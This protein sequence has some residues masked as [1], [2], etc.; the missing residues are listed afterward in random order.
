MMLLNRHLKISLVTRHIPLLSVPAELD[1]DK[2]YKNIFITHNY[3]KRFFLLKEPRIVVCGLNPHASDNGLIGKEENR[4][5]KPVLKGLK[6]RI[7][8]LDGPLSADVAI[9]KAYTKKYDCVIAIYHDQA[10]IALKI[11][12][13]KTGV[14]LTLGL[15]FVRTSPLHG[16][17]FDIAAKPGL[18]DPSSLMEA[19]RVAIQCTRNQKR[20]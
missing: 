3:L 2:L 10:L 12:D 8:H 6:A 16:T 9:Q 7:K 14:N 1:K 19:I 20:A 11:L 4:I 15:P 13:N 17:A 5:I 18:A